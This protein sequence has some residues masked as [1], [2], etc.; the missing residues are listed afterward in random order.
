MDRKD[1][2]NLVN[3]G[4]AAGMQG[5]T[6][7]APKSKPLT[8]EQRK[9]ENAV[10]YETDAQYEARIQQAITAGAK[11]LKLSPEGVAAAHATFKRLWDA[12][13]AAARKEAQTVRVEVIHEDQP[14][15][16]ID[17]GLQ[18]TTLAISTAAKV[19]D[20]TYTMQSGR[21]GEHRTFRIRTQA[22]D[23]KF[24][25]GKQVIGLLT[26][27]NNEGDYTNFGFI[28][29]AGT[30]DPWRNFR[31]TDTATLGVL[32]VAF[33]RQDALGVK[34]AE[35]GYTVQESRRCYR[36]HR[37]LTTPESISIGIGPE[38]ATR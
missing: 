21:T 1:I 3:A 12:E 26:G 6:K 7:R 13:L 4:L 22:K 27:R 10:K 5:R 16:T 36:C 14:A 2:K 8:E 23:A 25:P 29:N 38:C 9:A 11:G 19:F 33:L 18:A 32:L 17:V 15:V 37:V 31:N 28:T 30:L 24:A 35:A 34:L 20:G